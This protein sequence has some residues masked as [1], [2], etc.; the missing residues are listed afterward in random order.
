MQNTVDRQHRQ[1]YPIHTIAQGQ[2]QQQ[3]QQQRQQTT[4]RI[5]E[6]ERELQNLINQANNTIV[7]NNTVIDENT[8]TNQI[9]R[10]RSQIERERE[11]SN[12]QTKSGIKK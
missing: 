10:L 12:E 8:R 3:Q 7:N 1:Q 2:Q 6:L 4:P 9:N 11:R 5:V